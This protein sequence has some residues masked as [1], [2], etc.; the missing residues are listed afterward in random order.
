MLSLIAVVA[1]IALASG[2]G[3]ATRRTPSPGPARPV[4]AL[5]PI[6]HPGASPTAAV[7]VGGI[8]PAQSAGIDRVLAYTKSIS[9][10]SARKPEVALT[11]DDG[12][13]INTPEILAILEHERVPATFF[14]MG[15]SIQAYPAFARDTLAAGFTIANHTV[16]H[17]F[18]AHLSEPEQRRE[19]VG[20]S[21]AIHA[22]GAP[23]PR[24]FRPPFGSFDN[25]TE[26]L[27]HAERMLSVLWTVDTRDFSQPGT[28]QI[29]YTALSGA[30]PG[31]I[32]LMHD[33]GG[34]RGQTVAALPRIIN[35]LRR[36]HLRPVTVPQLILDDPPP[37][38]LPAPH[39]LS[40][41]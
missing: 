15:R 3:G 7:V 38:G 25:A 19:I 29:V 2:G 12:P 5:F 17:P 31:A 34:P 6:S 4:M 33:A 8:T 22:Y 13:G 40:G 21:Q 37:R 28:D 18:L 24:L 9:Q 41:R 16:T 39:N 32:I 1:L 35:G 26:R 36:K 14:E 30:K 23:S 11:F 10:G 20:A 27:V